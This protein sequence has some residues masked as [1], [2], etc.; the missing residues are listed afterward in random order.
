[1]K[2]DAGYVIAGIVL[3]VMSFLG[4]IPFFITLAIIAVLYKLE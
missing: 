4:P 1:M 3:T 2:D